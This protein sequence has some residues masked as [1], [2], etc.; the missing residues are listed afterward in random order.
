MRPWLNISIGWPARIF[1]VK[2]H[3]AMSGR[4]QGP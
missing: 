4:P 1:R 3:I 2:I